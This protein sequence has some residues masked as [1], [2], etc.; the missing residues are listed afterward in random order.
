MKQTFLKRR[1]EAADEEARGKFEAFWKNIL[2]RGGMPA[3]RN[4]FLY[5]DL[6]ASSDE[7]IFPAGT[8]GSASACSA[9]QNYL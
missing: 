8:R 7:G 6:P 1:N 5:G 4:C 9:V 3:F 2:V